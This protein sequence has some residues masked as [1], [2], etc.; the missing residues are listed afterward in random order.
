MAQTLKN[1][2]CALDMCFKNE[3]MDLTTKTL[4]IKVQFCSVEA[5]Q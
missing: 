5:H 4:C 3:I 1:I 2:Y